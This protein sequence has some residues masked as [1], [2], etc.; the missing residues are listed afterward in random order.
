MLR[1]DLCDT[2]FVC[3]FAILQYSCNTEATV[4]WAISLSLHSADKL[5]LATCDS[6]LFST[7]VC[8]VD[9]IHVGASTWPAMWSQHLQVSKFCKSPNYTVQLTINKPR[10]IANLIQYVNEKYKVSVAIRA[11]CVRRIGVWACIRHGCTALDKLL[12]YIRS[13]KVQPTNDR[14]CQYIDLLYSTKHCMGAWINFTIHSHTVHTA[15]DCV[16]QSVG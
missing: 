3:T 7:L 2:R 1:L 9:T 13:A 11:P 8:A 5:S 12:A 4:L 16:S 10:P 14:T 6:C 15:V